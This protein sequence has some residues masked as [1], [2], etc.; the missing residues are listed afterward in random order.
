[1]ADILVNNQGSL[2]ILVGA[3]T[4]GF[5]W[6]KENLDP[7]VMMWGQRGF[8]V[9]PR[10]VGAITDGAAEAGLEIQA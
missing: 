8:V 6:L 7:E 2:Y 1:M 10:Y 9:E 3:T 4:E 5:D